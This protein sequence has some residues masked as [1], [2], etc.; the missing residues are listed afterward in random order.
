MKRTDLVLL[1]IVF[2]LAFGL[3]FYDVASPAIPYMDESGH[4]PAATNYWDKGQFELDRWEHPPLRHMLLYGFLQVFGD[5]PYGWRMRNV[6]FGAATAVLVYLLAFAII[7]G[8]KTALLAALLIATDPLHVVLSRHTFCEVYGTAFFV[9]AILLYVRHN[10]RSLYLVM[11]AVFMGLA[12]GT[13]WN[14]VPGWLLIYA[15]TLYGN[16]NYKN[17]R[18]AIFV[19]STYILIPLGIYILSFYQWFGR[20]Y[21]FNEFIDF[22]INIYYSF[23]TYVP[24]NYEQGLV[25]LHNTKAV[26]WFIRPIIVGHGEY[27]AD[28]M[29]QFRLYINNL[30]VWIFSLPALIGMTIVAARKRSLALALPALIFCA[31]YLLFLSVKRPAFLYSVIP[32]L[33]FAFTAIAYGIGRLADRFGVMIFYV[34]LVGMLSWNLYL[35]PLVT[36]RQVPIAPYS[37]VIHNDGVQIR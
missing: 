15:I 13:K 37:Y 2:L 7:P 4:V 19:T 23:Q 31:S 17:I 16:G 29:G 11:S 25:F 24:E 33:P 32:L 26:D 36:A 22:I 35:Y 6:L 10:G 27:L 34:A 5:N 21:S 9:L 3:R 14:Y 30:P 18:S 1:C 8:R 28:G 20:G 12:V